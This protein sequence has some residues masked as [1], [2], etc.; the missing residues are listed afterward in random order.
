MNRMNSLPWKHIQDIR[1]C[2]NFKAQQMLAK[3]PKADSKV[4]ANVGE[5]V[6]VAM[7]A[8][9]ALPNYTGGAIPCETDYLVAQGRVFPAISIA[10]A[11]E[12]N[13][14]TIFPQM[15]EADEMRRYKMIAEFFRHD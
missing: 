15:D 7:A 13:R 8:V 1:D 14:K 5:L 12:F 11:E 2:E 9:G 3:M 10:Q 4:S 6:A